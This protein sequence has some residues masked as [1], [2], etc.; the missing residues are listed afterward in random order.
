M[1]DVFHAG[2]DYGSKLAG[3]TCICFREGDRLKILQSKKGEDAD[4]FILAWAQRHRPTHLFLDAPLSLPSVYS[5]EGNDYFYREADRQLG[6][7]SPLFLGGLTARA[8]RLC[9]MLAG[10][11]IQTVEVYP[12]ALVKQ[13]AAQKHYKKSIPSF[14]KELKQHMRAV[15]LPAIANWHQTDSTLAWLSG[16]RFLQNKV[17]RYGSDSEGIVWV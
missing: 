12:A 3:T 2:I 14:K 6:A 10:A 16:E 15:V 17:L 8:M 7:M 4:E 11:N 13:L 1:A 9:R 5:G